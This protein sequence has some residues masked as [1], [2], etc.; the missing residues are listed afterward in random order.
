[1]SNSIK[2]YSAEALKITFFCIAVT[3]LFKLVHASNNRLLIV[4]NMAV[5]SCAATFSVDKKYPAH[6]ILGGA[7]IISS[8][9]TGGIIGY[10]YPLIAKLLTV[11][12]GGLAF[13]LPKTKSTVTIFVLGCMMFLIFSSIPFNLVDGLKYLLDGFIVF[14]LFVGF[15]ILFDY[16]KKISS[17]KQLDKNEANKTI[18][19]IAALSLLFSVIFSYVLPLYYNFSHLY[20]IELTALLVIQSEQ[21]KMIQTSIKRILINAIGALIAIILFNFV[22]PNNFWPNFYLLAI[23]LFLIFFFG[24]SYTGRVLFIELFVLGFTHLLGDYKNA[25]ALDRA[26]LT[27]LGGL[28]VIIMTLMI[29][30]FEKRILKIMSGK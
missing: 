9:I 25:I 16:K 6:V 21:I 22:V 8:I 27:L 24:F 1:M 17:E 28:I 19:V 15:F 14:I 30:F 5:M 11:I 10:Y 7:V 4:F 12:Y 3:E 29:Y 20:W 18:A 13:Y 2:I 23:L 26:I